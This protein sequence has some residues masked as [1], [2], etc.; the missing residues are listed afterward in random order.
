VR[1]SRTSAQPVTQQAPRQT[2]QPRPPARRDPLAA[3]ESAYREVTSPRADMSRLIVDLRPGRE[4][5]LLKSEV[6]AMR[7]RAHLHGGAAATATE[8]AP[9][10]APV[11]GHL[12]DDAE[13]T[14]PTGAP[15]APP[16]AQLPGWQRKLGH[17]RRAASRPDEANTVIERPAS[18]LPGR[19]GDTQ[20][21]PSAR[22][23][24]QA[25]AVGQTL[26][27]LEGM[28]DNGFVM[29]GGFKGPEVMALQTLLRRRGFRV[30]TTGAIDEDTTAA[31]RALQRRGGLAP[32]GIVDLQVLGLLKGPRQA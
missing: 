3:I 22:P 23:P 1:I 9:T 29:M 13:Q 30:R 8:R 16:A 18:A 4:H 7:L 26:R 24:R 12:S 27:D 2:E 31:V 6:D 19:P 14:L 5:P 21:A 20:P 32:T 10:P 11:P 17:V 28:L 25:R 15:A